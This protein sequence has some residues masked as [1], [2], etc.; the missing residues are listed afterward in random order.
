MKFYLCFQFGQKYQKLSYNSYNDLF[1]PTIDNNINIT[2]SLNSQLTKE[3]LVKIFP[4]AIILGA[5]ALT[6]T[7]KAQAQ[8]NGDWAIF[9]LR[10]VLSTNPLPD[11][12]PKGHPFFLMEHKGFYAGN[13]GG[14]KRFLNQITCANH[15][16]QFGPNFLN[17]CADN[18]RFHLEF[19][20]VPTDKKERESQWRTPVV[21]FFFKPGTQEVMITP[22]CDNQG[23][24]TATRP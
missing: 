13:D 14:K 17:P 7:P 20:V 6:S 12:A 5:L 24:E 18:S 15:T 21:V 10:C 11:Y 3:Q 2:Y 23:K 22:K 16:A 4:L 19:S 8:T 1:Y 9:P